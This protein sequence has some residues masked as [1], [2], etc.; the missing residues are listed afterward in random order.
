MFFFLFFE[1][2]INKPKPI[3]PQFFLLAETKKILL[4]SVRQIYEQ[5]SL[6]LRPNS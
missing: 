2:L 3:E 4:L 5:A 1:M 6:S